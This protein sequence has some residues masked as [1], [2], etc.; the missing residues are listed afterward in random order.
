[1]PGYRVPISAIWVVL[2]LNV[3]VILMCYKSDNVAE[4]E[5]DHNAD[6][7][8]VFWHILKPGLDDGRWTVDNGRWTMDDGQWTM[9]LSMVTQ[10]ITS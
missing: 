9:D 10:L 4:R 5:G 7:L 2:K 3:N 1:M 6:L 8:P